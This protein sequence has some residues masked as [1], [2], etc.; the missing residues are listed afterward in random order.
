MER[1]LEL[2][3]L[4]DPRLA[5]YMDVLNAATP[6]AFQSEPPLGV[7]ITLRQV[8]LS[9]RHGNSIYAPRAYCGLYRILE[10]H[11]EPE[12]GYRFARLGHQ[13]NLQRQE[14]APRSSIEFVYGYFIEP[15]NQ[16]WSE[17]QIAFRRSWESGLSTG[18]Y[19]HMGYSAMFEVF[20]AL[21]GGTPLPQ[22]V[23]QTETTMRTCRQLGE[24]TKA[25][26]LGSLL[27]L[28]QQLSGRQSWQPIVPEQ[29][30]SGM[31]MLYSQYCVDLIH[32]YHSED[33][34]AARSVVAVMEPLL[35]SFRG[36]LTEIVFYLYGGLAAASRGDVEELERAREW[37]AGRTCQPNFEAPHC[38]LQAELHR[39]RCESMEAADQY[40]QAIALAG[41]FGLLGVEALANQLA[42]EF[43]MQR[44]KAPFAGYYLRA[45]HRLFR[46]WG[47]ASLAGRLELRYSALLSNRSIDAS[48]S[49]NQASDFIDYASLAR[50]A[51]AI[52]GE[53]V[54]E[55]LLGTLTQLLIENAGAQTGALILEHEGDWEIRALR[56]LESGPVEVVSE[57]LS[58][59]EVARGVVQYALR[60][61]QKVVIGDARLHATFG[62][63]E[64]V[65]RKAP[66]SIFCAPIRHKG[67]LLGALYLENNLLTEAFDERRLSGLEI[68][69]AQVGV[70]L[71]NARLFA[72]ERHQ[73]E[74][75]EE[76]VGHR[77][78]ELR[79]ANA[80]LR[81]ESASRERME[82]ELRLGQKLQAVGQLAA[83]VA[84]EIN[85]P[86]Q[87][88]QDNLSFVREVSARWQDLD[89]DS[90][91]VPEAL[92]AALEGV[93]RVTA[94]VRA[95]K[96][97]SYPDQSEKAL[98][99]LNLAIENTL[100]V[101]RNEYKLVAD[102]VT[103]FG[104]LPPYLCFAGE[105]NQVVLNLLVNA[106]HAVEETGRRGLIRVATRREEGAL[107]VEVSD[108]GNGIPEDVQSRIFDPFFTT[109]D[110]GK[111]TGQGLAIA[112]SAVERHGGQLTFTTHPGEG[113][114]FSLRLPLQA[115]GG[116][117]RT[118]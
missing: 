22:V 41:K 89:E 85:T 5:T 59:A 104:S 11:G 84:H 91:E 71:E 35:P 49:T 34:S 113:T 15:W 18:D 112:R 17:V 1:L 44:G 82:N 29:A 118:D 21:L 31:M 114:T 74:Q 58:Q 55:R 36:Y 45:A 33:P 88:I 117:S 8:T 52:S 66:R 50:A 110:V 107:V 111:G 87:Y 30:P 96:A 19:A 54:L 60:T 16:P 37:M 103:E 105:L 13:L 4:E 2:P 39:L 73:A 42:G 53:I 100:L 98:V 25:Y 79:Q 24:V 102:V 23:A 81:E 62:Q 83:G 77:T 43:W 72:R 46:H 68:L 86:M 70:S 95:M 63:E 51:Q 99:D 12:A 3:N 14:T 48:S 57:L 108:D 28:L 97:F 69:L 56:R 93:R 27:D 67:R 40:D 116:V 65:R 64:Y 101:A 7:L 26:F 109:K 6:I 61:G 106:A 10:W 115:C 94:I 76:L 9:L 32:A 75:L 92:D 80:L 38:L 78:S 20:A 90:A 47:A